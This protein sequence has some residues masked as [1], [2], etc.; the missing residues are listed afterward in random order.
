MHVLTNIINFKTS[1]KH[2][3]I[4]PYTVLIT[5]MVA[6]DN[7]ILTQLVH[8]WT[9]YWS[10]MVSILINLYPQHPRDERVPTPH[11]EKQQVLYLYIIQ[12]VQLDC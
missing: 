5:V 3:F 11:S 2:N 6:I 4:L 7:I 8:M 12:D 1:I 10:V 9:S